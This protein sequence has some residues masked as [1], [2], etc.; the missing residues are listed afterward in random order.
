[1]GSFGINDDLVGEKIAKWIDLQNRTRVTQH[2][3]DNQSQ[4]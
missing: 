4:L 2:K 3:L 1:M